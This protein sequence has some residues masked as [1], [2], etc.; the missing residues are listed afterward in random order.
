MNP[1]IVSPGTGVQQRAN[2]TNTSSAPSTSMALLERRVVGA[3]D[4]NVSMV[5][6][7]CESSTPIETTSLSMMEAAET[8]PSPTAEYKASISG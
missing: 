8:C 2:F 4:G 6:S 7:G 3:R 1:M 5:G